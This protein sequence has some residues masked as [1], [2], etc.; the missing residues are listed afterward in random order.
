MRILDG[1][2]MI[3]TKSS[4]KN[5]TYELINNRIGKSL[6]LNYNGARILRK[7][8]QGKKINEKYKDFILNLSSLGII[9]EDDEI[10]HNVFLFIATEILD[11]K[12]KRIL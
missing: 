11:M 10:S 4:Q 9:V 6:V 8:H 2:R 1:T 3:K 7:I 5:G 12:K